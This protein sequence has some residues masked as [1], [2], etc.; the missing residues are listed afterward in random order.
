VNP[1]DAADEPEA[2]LAV[3]SDEPAARHKPGCAFGPGFY[4]VVY[5][6]GGE[7]AVAYFDTRGQADLFIRLLPPG[8]SPRA[9]RD[10]GCLE[11]GRAHV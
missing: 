2:T 10:A 6:R 8:R 1:R 7:T 4:R 9:H 3:W 11:I 5:D